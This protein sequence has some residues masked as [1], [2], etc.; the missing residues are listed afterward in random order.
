M[1]GVFVRR[2]L[3]PE[4]RCVGSICVRYL[5]ATEEGAHAGMGMAAIGAW[6]Y[7]NIIRPFGDFPITEDELPARW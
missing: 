7:S 1:T 3:D 6:S 4:S 2:G 5:W